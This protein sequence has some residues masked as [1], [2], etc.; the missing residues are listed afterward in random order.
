MRLGDRSLCG[1]GEHAG[2]CLEGLMAGMQQC[3]LTRANSPA[4]AGTYQ[5]QTEQNKT[6]LKCSASCGVG[7]RAHADLS[8]VVVDAV[9]VEEEG[10]ERREQRQRGR[11]RGNA[12]GQQGVAAEVERAERGERRAEEGGRERFARDRREEAA[13][14]VQRVQR[15]PVQTGPQ[16]LRSHVAQR[17]PREH[18]LCQLR[19]LVPRVIRQWFERE[20]GLIRTGAVFRSGM[21]V[22]HDVVVRTAFVRLGYTSVA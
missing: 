21:C 13:P 9:A 6:R 19:D 7:V 4:R 14:H 1:G 2:G 12:R 8:A 22:E 3:V 11:K 18:Q 16:A 17:T 15:Q 20:G 5:A 10:L